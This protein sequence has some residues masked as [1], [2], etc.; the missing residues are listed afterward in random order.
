MNITKIEALSHENYIWRIQVKAFLI[1][2]D[3]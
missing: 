1:M 3:E 2:N